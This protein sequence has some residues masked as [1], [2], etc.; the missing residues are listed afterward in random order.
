[1]LGDYRVEALQDILPTPALCCLGRAA[2]KPDARICR[3]M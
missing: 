2:G 1:M 3:V